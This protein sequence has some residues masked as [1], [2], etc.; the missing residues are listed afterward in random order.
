[1]PCLIID[2][3]TKQAASSFK[4]FSLWY[5]K[6]SKFLFSRSLELNSIGHNFWLIVSGKHLFPEVGGKKYFLS[7]SGSLNAMMMKFDLRS[8]L[9]KKTFNLERIWKNTRLL[10]TLLMWKKHFVVSSADT[11]LNKLQ[12]KVS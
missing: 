10:Y 4:S 5:I 12:Y 8:N 9:K 11:T 2:H 7:F 1:M 3:I 6:P